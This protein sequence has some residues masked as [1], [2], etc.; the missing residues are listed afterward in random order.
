MLFMLSFS[1][2]LILAKSNR[3]SC[4]GITQQRETMLQNW[5]RP[6]P[7][8]SVSTGIHA[9]IFIL[10]PTNNWV[11]IRCN[12]PLNKDPFT[13]KI[14]K[15]IHL[16]MMLIWFGHNPKRPL[17]DT[18][19][20]ATSSHIK[21]VLKFNSLVKLWWTT[22]H[23]DPCVIAIYLPIY[24]FAPFALTLALRCLLAV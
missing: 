2:R 9:S 14:Y 19:M 7:W 21:P 3:K 23:R 17:L 24:V 20:N 6:S 4:S 12:D 5:P 13:F 15:G 1:E 22:G 10:P 8:C 16:C 18:W 11:L